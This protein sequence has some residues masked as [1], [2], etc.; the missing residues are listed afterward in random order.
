MKYRNEND[1][2][3]RVNFMRSTEELMDQLTV[4]DFISYLEENAEFEDETYEYID[5]K[6][7]KCKAY[8]FKE[9]N[10]NLHKEFLITED[11]RV[12]YW[13]SLLS[14]IELVDREEKVGIMKIK[15][16]KNVKFGTNKLHVVVTGWALYEEGKGYIAFSCDRDNYGILVPYIPCGGK[17]ALQSILD[18]GGFCSF[19]SMEYVQELGA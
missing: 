19:E 13:R 9:E 18:A 17:R 16:L 6:T 15:R 7:V 10:S 11:G 12:F 1:N 8:D 3:Y 4:K 14:K 2:R 5:G